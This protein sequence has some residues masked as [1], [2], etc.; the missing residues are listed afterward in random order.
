MIGGGKVPILPDQRLR[1]LLLLGKHNPMIGLHQL[2]MREYAPCL[3]LFEERG[4][5]S[6]EV[7]KALC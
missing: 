1:L 3:M 7:Q 2:L 5:V 4:L 6:V